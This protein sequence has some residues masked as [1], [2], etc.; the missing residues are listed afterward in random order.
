VSDEN[1]SWLPNLVGGVSIWKL[2]PDLNEPQFFGGRLLVPET[3]GSDSLPVRVEWDLTGLV[4][5][6]EAREK[7]ADRIEPAVAELFACLERT[8]RVFETGGS[9]YDR[10][11]AAF[12]VPALDA[13][14]GAHYFFSPRDGQLKVINWGASPRKIR[15]EKHYLFGYQEF[16]D[17]I[18]KE[19]ESGG[20][21]GAGALGGVGPGPGAGLVAD[22]GADG[23]AGAEAGGEATDEKKDE[24]EKKGEHEEKDEKGALW[25]KPWWM[26][27]LYLVGLLFLIGLVFALLSDCQG[28]SGSGSAGGLDGGLAAG[29]D[30]GARVDGAL[31]EAPIYGHASDDAGPR[32]TEL[33][34]DGG[35]ASEQ[36][37]GGAGAEPADSGGGGEGSGGGGEGSGGGG[38]GSG[39][40]GEGSGEGGEGSGPGSGSGSEEAPPT[41][42]DGE[43]IYGEVRTP[44]GTVYWAPGEGGRAV[45]LPSRQYFHPD[46]Q[47]WRIVGGTRK[48]HDYAGSGANFRVFLR[49]GERFDGVR[50]QWRDGAGV[51][52]DH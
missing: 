2:A 50:V 44:T 51:W 49:P 5:L 48:V 12:T 29:A 36:A 31:A 3:E 9:G 40:G 34:G 39:G 19:Q 35:A 21:S 42:E 32:A 52:H 15:H 45:Q 43:P 4:P 24:D 20:P 41:N 18:R 17:L 26:W 27:I 11:K 1:E 14:G 16:A 33:H 37:D 10:Y 46:A 22:A 28:T 23:A 30:A 13:D 47:Q 38:E 25:G 8:A 7:H 6:P